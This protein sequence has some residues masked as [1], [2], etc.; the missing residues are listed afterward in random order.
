MP[1]PYEKRLLRVLDYIHDN[2]A[3][4]L[5]LDQL[6]DVAAMSRFH[7]HR[8]FHAMTGETCAQATRRIRLH[9]AACWLVQTDQPVDEI[10]KKVGIPNRQSFARIFKEG[11]A[12]TPGQFRKSGQLRPQTPKKDRKDC[13]MFDVTLK[14]APARHMIALS[15]KGPYLEIGRAFEKLGAIA[16]SRGLWPQVEAMMGLYYD[17]PNAVAEKDLRSH[18]GLAVR[19][20]VETP[21]GLEEIE[22]AAGKLAVLQFKGPYSGLK[23]AYDYLYGEWLPKSGEEPRDAPAMEIY[24]NNPQDTPPEELRT[25]ICLPLV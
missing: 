1:D 20:G 14:E 12:M 22:I 15:H 13:P 6:A 24:L 19:P 16:G 25:D 9:R 21:E 3:G 8:V 7:W 17:D 4:D 23:A 18:A 11:F 5:S 2:P 10:A